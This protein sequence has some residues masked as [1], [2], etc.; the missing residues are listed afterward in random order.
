MPTRCHEVRRIFNSKAFAVSDATGLNL[1]G[2]KLPKRQVEDYL[3]QM[4][5]GVYL[6][7]LKY[8]NIEAL[9]QSNVHRKEIATQDGRGLPGK[10]WSKA[11]KNAENMFER[12]ET[13]PESEWEKAEGIAYTDISSEPVRNVEAG[14][15]RP[16][17]KTFRFK[18][19]LP[20]WFRD[21]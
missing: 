19:A 3:F 14:L 6:A 8:A 7:H 16:P 5:R 13:F 10:A 2:I 11:E 18:T 17:F 20:E 4:P 1:H 21:I 15:V 12:L 9:A